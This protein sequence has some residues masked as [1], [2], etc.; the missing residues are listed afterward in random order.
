M[1]KLRCQCAPPRELSLSPKKLERG[2]VICAECSSRFRTDAEQAMAEE[3][4][5]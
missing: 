3:E 5:G 1:V 2:A 4:Y